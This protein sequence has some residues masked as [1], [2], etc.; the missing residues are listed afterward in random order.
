MYSVS[1]LLKIAVQSQI[2]YKNNQELCKLTKD[3]LHPKSRLS[4]LEEKIFPKGESTVLVNP[5]DNVTHNNL[6]TSFQPTLNVK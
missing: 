5:D 4:D 3:N 2:I 6:Q 1:K